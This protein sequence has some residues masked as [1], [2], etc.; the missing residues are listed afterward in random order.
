VKASTSIIGIVVAMAL[1]LVIVL[2]GS[3]QG[4]ER[5]GLPLFAWIAVVIFAIQWVV[6]IPSWFAHSEHFFDLTGSVTYLVVVVACLSAVDSIEPRSLLIA[7]MVSIWALRLGWF[8][9]TRVRA[10]GSDSRFDVMKHR[11][12]WFLMTW[13]LQGLWILITSGAALAAMSRPGQASIGPTVLL[14]TTLWV[15]GFAIEVAADTQKRRFRSKV[16][17]H[18]RF[19]TTG[20]WAYSRHPNYFG[21]IVLWVGVAVA[22]MPALSSWGYA[23]LVSPFFVWALLTRISGIPLLETAA[24]RRWGG[25]EDYETYKAHTP[26]LMFRPGRFHRVG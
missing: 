18:D 7:A 12:A 14:G 24:D 2:A 10:A 6:F 21:E 9:S 11:F 4:T 1:S 13:T 3:H 22:A 16:E 25:Q 26:T 23:T 5:A 20:L 8:L 17:D 15:V 19:I